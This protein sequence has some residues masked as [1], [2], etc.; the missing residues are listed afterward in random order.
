MKENNL[1][2][3]V[4]FEKERAHTEINK[5]YNE[6]DL[7]VLSSYFEASACV[8]MEAWATDTPILSI[9]KQGIAELIPKH[10]VNNLLVNEKSPALLKEKILGEYQRKRKYPFDEKYDI[11]NIIS[12]FLNYNFFKRNV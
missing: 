10:E 2:S 3:F 6:I 5:F 8:L 9:K 11:K 7:F 1:S 12:E 4:I